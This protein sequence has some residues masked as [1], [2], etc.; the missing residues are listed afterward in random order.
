[1]KVQV[2]SDLHWEFQRDFGLSQARE[3]ASG[4]GDVLVLAGDI[5][6]ATDVN[7]YFDTFEIL[8]DRFG[9]ILYVAGNHEFYHSSL[10]AAR[11]WLRSL[12][13]KFPNI[14]F[15]DNRV[16]EIGGTRFLGTTLWFPY[17]A[18][19]NRYKRYMTDFQVIKND[20]EEFYEENLKAKE[21]I[22]ANQDIDFVITHHLPGKEVVA[23]QYKNNYLN[24][25]FVGDACLQLA[26]TTARYFVWGHTHTS[27]ARMIEGTNLMLLC[28]P[29]GYAKEAEN[30][31]FNPI[32]YIE[33]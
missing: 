10:G 1:M 27:M 23:E 22:N 8:S 5:C 3:I 26:R 32:A 14:H 15:M 13:A 33:V 24:R 30:P 2:V 31:A 12:E 21:F 19:N 11:T 9:A 17:E 4:K 20:I 16:K 29:F 7:N 18:K 28:N 25:F 6:L